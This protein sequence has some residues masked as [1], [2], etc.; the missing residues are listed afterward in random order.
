M[1]MM[2]ACTPMQGLERKARVIWLYSY[3]VIWLHSY[4][5][6]YMY[7]CIYSHAGSRGQSS[8]EQR[9]AVGADVCAPAIHIHMFTYLHTYVVI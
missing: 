7:V 3:I 9:D 4:I 6:I 8:T 5:S 2:H 1:C